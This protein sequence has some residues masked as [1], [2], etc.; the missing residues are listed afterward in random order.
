MSLTSLQI[1]GYAENKVKRLHHGWFVVRNRTLSEVEKGI[2]PMERS[3]REQEFFNQW[4]W[5][6]L[7]EERRGAEALKKYLAELLCDRIEKVFPTILSDIRARLARTAV[8]LE[9]LEVPRKSVEQKR[10]YLTRIAHDLNQLATQGLRGRYDRIAGHD[11]KLRMKVRDANDSFASEMNRN[12]H[13]LAFSHDPF[14]LNAQAGKVRPHRPAAQTIPFQ[15]HI[16]RDYTG[17]VSSFQSISCMGPYK[18]VSFEELRLSHYSQAQPPPLPEPSTSAPRS[19]FGAPTSESLT[20]TIYLGQDSGGSGS[21]GSANSTP[22]SLN[23]PFGQTSSI[24]A[25]LGTPSST[26]QGKT[27]ITGQN[28]G[29]PFSFGNPSSTSQSKTNTTGQN[30]SSP[31]ANFGTP[32]STSQSKTKTTGQNSVLPLATKRTTR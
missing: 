23:K 3:S 19:I 2:G 10:A 5:N 20:K 8:E 11:M 27:N 15:A 22:Q 31:F 30:S 7:P 14:R 6:Q 25:S 26:S 24:F 4:P 17:I 18:D 9:A 32:S 28:S 29:G 21:F 12:G 1:V 13:F 16:E